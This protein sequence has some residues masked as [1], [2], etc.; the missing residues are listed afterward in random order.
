MMFPAAWSD[1]R[2]CPSG[3]PAARKRT[4]KNESIITLSSGT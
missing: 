4:L 1:K 3:N 2:I